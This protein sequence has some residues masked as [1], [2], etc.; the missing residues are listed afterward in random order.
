MLLDAFSDDEDSIKLCFHSN[1]NLFNLTRLQ[2][3]TKVKI[4][5]VH[6]LLFADDC[7]LNGSSEAGLH[8][9]T[10]K[11][12][13]AC[14][15]F[16]LTISTQKTQV[17]C[18]LALHTMQPNPRIRLK[19]NA[20]EIV[21]KF[22]YF[23]SVLSKNVTI[24]DEVKNR[25]ANAN[26]TFGRLSKNVWDQEGLSAHTRLKVYNAIVHSTLLYTRETW[27]AYSRHVMKLNWFPLNCLHRLL[28]IW[29]WHRVP[30]TEVIN[31]AELLSIHTYLHKTQLHWAG[32]V[33]RMDDEHLPKHL[34]F[35]ELIEGKR[36][37]GGQ[38]KHFKDTLNAFLK[39]FSIDPNVWENLASDRASWHNAVH[40][41]PASY[42][43]QWTSHA[44]MK[45]AEHK[46]K[47]ACALADSV[48]HVCPH[49]GR[50][51]HTFIGLISRLQSH[52]T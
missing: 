17:M 30:D 28:N 9:N 26:A 10:N 1:R 44:I 45:R 5:S 46:A 42:D 2:A 40:H 7:A 47:A 18:Q 39:D 15:A 8:W 22:T 13:S 38:K 52:Q 23:G 33:L 34:L 36:S 21:D 35:G 31:H 11:F 4:T 19:G 24:D 6:D 14:N 50:L 27:S 20:L 41:G 37:I 49:C 16:G 3:Q 51:F 32:H 43:S 48:E 12:S 29:W 25:L